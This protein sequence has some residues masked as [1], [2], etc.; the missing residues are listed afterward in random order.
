MLGGYAMGA[1]SV[2]N[3]IRFVG[4]MDDL[5][6]YN[7][8]LSAEEVALNWENAGNINDPSLFA[9]YSFDEGPGAIV[10]KNLGKVGSDADLYNGQLFGGKLYSDVVTQTVNSV[11]PALT[12]S[13]I[14]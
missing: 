7:R 2:E 12:V 1:T 10:F 3:T 6:F 14:I 5:A 8:I 9:Y 11:T 13:L 4:W